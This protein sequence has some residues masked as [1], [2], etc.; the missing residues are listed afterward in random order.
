MISRLSDYHSGPAIV[1]FRGVNFFTKDG[2]DLEWTVETFP[3]NVDNYQKI[4]ERVRQVPTKITFTPA[5][6]WT[7]AILAVLYDLCRQDYGDYVTPVRTLGAIA[8]NVVTITAH[9]LLTGDAAFVNPANAAST[10]PTGLSIDTIYY[11]R[12][13]SAN[14]ISFHPTRADAVAGTN[15]IT[16]SA[17]TGLARLTVNNPCVIQNTDGSRYTFHNAA[18]T[19]MPSI[20]LTA[21]ATPFDT[22]E[23]SFFLQDNKVMS[24]ADAMYTLDTASYP[25]DGGIDPATVLTQSPN[26]AWGTVAPWNAFNT[27]DGV[28]IDFATTTRDIEIDGFPIK[29][30]QFNGLDVT[31]K[32]TPIGPDQGDVPSKLLVQGAGASIGRS[33]AS[34]GAPLSMSSTG[35]YVVLPFAGLRGGPEQFSVTKERMGEQT[36]VAT[37]TFDTNGKPRPVVVVTTDISLT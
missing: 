37:R 30:K 2:F 20:H 3:I 29:T 25:G 5:G 36:W 31:A 13:V 12:V 28:K 35:M 16:I 19:K 14:T 34:N 27:K 6:Q 33:L 8:S 7:N 32:A 24:D 11:V 9:R 18:V 4:D 17:G 23:I 21:G 10:N 26:V 1:S 15:I 22:V